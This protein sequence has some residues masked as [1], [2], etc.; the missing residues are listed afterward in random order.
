MFTR[1]KRFLAASIISLTTQHVAPRLYWAMNNIPDAKK[2]ASEENLC[3]GT[4]D[5]WLLWKLTNGD[6]HAT[7]YSHVCTTVLFDTYQ[8]KYSDAILNVLGLPRS[9]LPEIKD[10]GGLFGHVS[11][12]HFGAAIPI[13]ALISDQTS[14]MFAQGCWEKGDMKCTMGTGMFMSINTGDK[15]HASLSGMYPTVGWKIGSEIAFLAEANFPSCGSVCEW[16]KSFG[17]FSDP[18]ETE[19]IASSV[20]NSDGVCF[21]PAFDGIQAPY[22][23]PKATA[24]VIGITHNTTKENMV[25][26]MLESI[27]FTFK[28][29]YDVAEDE[30]STPIKKIRVD[31]GVSNN[32]FVID[33]VSDLLGREVE[34]PSDVDM[35]VYGAIYVAGLAEGFW[36]SKEEI[37]NIWKLGYVSRPR[38]EAQPKLEHSY[39]TWQRAVERSLDWYKEI[40][41]KTTD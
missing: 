14:A 15:P 28:Q 1:S 10:T 33:T 11:R 30:L 4:V 26:A 36:K 19:A 23:D 29:L 20:E 16:G 37:K 6:V 35:T 38:A 21:V 9:I 13:T 7:D 34:R 12:E 39:K 5:T 22:N 24:S 25:R 41:T 17:L 18:S 40:E 32:N 2:L 3:F 8:M 27:A 31:G